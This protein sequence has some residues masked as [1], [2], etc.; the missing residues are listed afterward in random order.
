MNDSPSAMKVADLSPDWFWG[1]FYVH[2]LITSRKRDKKIVFSI[3]DE[4]S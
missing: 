2:S 3:H 4:S 1:F